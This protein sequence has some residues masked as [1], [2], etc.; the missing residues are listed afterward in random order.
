MQNLM[1][2]GTSLCIHGVFDLGFMTY[3]LSS[4]CPF[5]NQFNPFWEKIGLYNNYKAVK[6]T[7]HVLQKVIHARERKH[8]NMETTKIL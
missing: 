3:T 5:E 4:F 8:E 1:Y 2:L 7:Q 6:K